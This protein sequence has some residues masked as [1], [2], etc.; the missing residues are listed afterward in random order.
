MTISPS[1]TKAPS[2]ERRTSTFKGEIGDI[3]AQVQARVVQLA[4]GDPSKIEA[5][6]SIEDVLSYLEKTQDASSKKDSS[7]RSA[8]EKTLQFIDTV[9][10]LVA[11]G[12]GEAFPPSELCFNAVSMVIHAWQDYQGVFESLATLLEKC[13]Q[14]FQRLEYHIQG[15]MDAKLA[16]VAV[17]HLQ[18]FVE[19]C[20][21]TIKLRRSKRR[22]LSVFTKLLFLNDNDIA[23]LLEKMKSL[24]DEEGR[25]VA[26]QTFSFAAQA[27]VS[28]RENL[29]ISRAVNSKIDM[30]IANRSDSLKESDKRRRKERILDTLAFD[31]NKLDQE[32]REPDP[33]WQRVYYNYRKRVVPGTGQWVFDE[34]EFKAWEGGSQDSPLILAI[35]GTEGSGKSY[36]SS[37]IIRRLRNRSSAAT[38]TAPDSESDSRTLLAFYFVEG[39]SKEELKRTNHIDVITKSLIWQFVQADMSY[40]KSVAGICERNRDM[41]PHEIAAKLLFEN[42]DI[43]QTIDAN[44]FIVIDGLNDVVGDALVPFLGNAISSARSHHK[45]RILLTGRPRAF[46][47]ISAAD[48]DIAFKT[49][50]ISERNRPD[51]DMYIES[52]MDSIDALRNKERFGVKDLRKKIRIAL[53][54]KTSGDYFRVN[55]ILKRIS[56]LDYVNDIDQVLENAGRERSQQIQAEIESL[57]NVR[58]AKEIA[59]INEIILWILYGREW[60][61][62]RQMAAVLY[63]QSG[64]LSLLTLEAKL[65]LKYTLFEVDSDGDV[66]FRSYEIVDLIL[67]GNQSQAPT[68]QATKRI[69]PE[70]VDIIRHFLRT[71]CPPTLYEKFDFETVFDQKLHHTSGTIHRDDKDTAEA[72]LA[73]T[74]LRVLTEKRDARREI[75][76]PYAVNYFHQHLAAV[77]LSLVDRKWKIVVGPLLAKLFLDEDSTDALLWTDDPEAARDFAWMAREA[78]FEGDG[79]VREVARWLKESVALSDVSD[80]RDRA[81]VR[82][83]T[84]SSEPEKELLQRLAKRMVVHWLREETRQVLA[85]YAFSFIFG[86]LK[87]INRS[88]EQENPAVKESA[89]DET[90]TLEDITEIENWSFAL[91]GHKKDSLW[92][93][94]VAVILRNYNFLHQA[95]TRC[96]HA[97]TLDPSNW[98]ASYYLAH[99]VSS[100]SEAINILND[101]IN[102]LGTDEKWMA[103]RNHVSA[104]AEMLFDRGQRYWNAEQFDQAIGSFTESVKVNYAGFKRILTIIEQYY[105]RRLWSDILELLKTIQAGAEASSNHNSSTQKNKSHLSKMLVDLASEETFHNIILQTAVETGQF[106]FIEDVYEDAIKLS[107][108]ME[109]YTSL[110]Y[111]R[112]H[113]ANEIFQQDSPDVE[114]RAVA[115]WE[116]ALKEDLPR[117]FL[118]IDYVLPFLTVKLAPIYLSRARAA[119]PDSETAREYLDRIASITPDDGSASSASTSQSNVI[120]PAK[121]YLARYY[122]ITGDKKRAKQIVRS[123]VKIALEMLSDDDADNDYLAYWRLLLVFLPLNDDDNALAAVAMA[124]AASRIAFANANAGHGPG[125]PLIDEPKRNPNPVNGYVK[126]HN[127]P[128]GKKERKEQSP[129]GRPA[130]TITT[131]LQTHPGAGPGTPETRRP[132]TPNSLPR[133]PELK[134]VA[135]ADLHSHSEPASAPASVRGDADADVE[136]EEEDAAVPIFA[137]CDGGCGRYWQ[138]ASEMWWC[139]DCINLT[140][141]KECFEQLRGGTLPL[142]VCDKDHAFLEVPRLDINGNGNGTDGIAAGVPRG[143]VP[144]KGKAISLE[145]WKR[146]IVR[147]Y[148]E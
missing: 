11:G 135:L 22:K 123:A 125:M 96:R 91:L 12:T 112:Y 103:E 19:I 82:S 41:D 81:W 35:E 14:Y 144:F 134:P 111:I 15:G 51:I 126:D 57:N 10:G 114:E 86:A 143:Y 71:V 66:D 142:K 94:Q 78:W 26:A 55:T 18:L 116:T 23:D 72:K 100:N 117:S 141:D 108:Q 43:G 130:P 40:M 4:G 110:Y 64:E 83:L 73:V 132:S 104:Y 28:T 8:F 124:A 21:R 25:L 133:T 65:Q 31:E 79:A 105:D 13:S 50:H 140:F 102:R 17:Q 129:R 88:D 48:K 62:P 146:G 1:S 54:D 33:Y 7:I 63:V 147:D 85:V 42:A 131:S 32:K 6:L 99:V 148:I 97:L 24:V 120:L 115:L 30:L 128:R 29:A 34:N 90:P 53:R 36:L 145:E 58:N 5:D 52:R 106:A 138:D 59:E 109:A 16:K 92:Q 45:I 93:V 74:C 70:E 80:E 9:G 27:V 77:D 121:L 46:E 137:I 68:D 56:H 113:Y 107:T 139:K 37:T 95:E 75:I 127:S 44:F 101:I 84:E 2:L 98:R 60:F 119:K 89:E 39:D 67:E 69:L 20:D 47:Q 38:A 118:D 49:I 136:V 87:K 76:R 122:I 61:K 3:W